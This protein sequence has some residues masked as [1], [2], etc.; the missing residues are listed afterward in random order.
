MFIKNET[1]LLPT[2][3]ARTAPE[4]TGVWPPGLTQPWELMASVGW[5]WGQWW[6]PN[7]PPGQVPRALWG[8]DGCQHWLLIVCPALLLSPA[9]ACLSPFPG[10]KPAGRSS[11]RMAGML[12]LKEKCC[13]TQQ[14]WHE[15]FAHSQQHRQ[16]WLCSCTC[17]ESG[18]IQLGEASSGFLCRPSAGS[19]CS[20]I[21]KDL[22]GPFLFPGSG[23]V[24]GLDALMQQSGVMC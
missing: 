11:W 4:I 8:M 18:E 2:H 12:S 22:S 9:P 6:T 14:R 7:C 17:R 16:S 5:C 3:L 23:Q 24:E 20:V 15:G 13:C 1:A 21:P 19:G 10:V